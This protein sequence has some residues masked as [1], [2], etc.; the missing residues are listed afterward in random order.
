M[1]QISV[2]YGFI[3][4]IREEGHARRFEDRLQFL[5]SGEQVDLT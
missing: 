2:I 5:A 1:L 4:D 3:S